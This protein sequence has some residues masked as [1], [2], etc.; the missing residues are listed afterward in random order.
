MAGP[1]EREPVGFSESEKRAAEWEARHDVAARGRVGDPFAVQ[2]Y[3]ARRREA[4]VRRPAPAPA[5]APPAAA[6]AAAAPQPA[7]RPDAASRSR[8][9]V[10][11]DGSPGARTALEVALAEAARRG[12]E[13]DVVTASPLATVWSGGV[14]YTPEQV[15]QIR[16]GAEQ[17]IHA[18]VDEVLADPLAGTPGIDAVDVRV[19]AIE[20]HAARVLIAAAEDADLLVVG[21]R[22]RG[23]VRSTLL[24]SVALHCIGS[25]PCPV[26]V[27]HADARA[28]DQ[29]AGPPRVGAG[30]DGSPG[31]HA[32]LAAAVDEAARVGGEVEVLACYAVTDDWTVPGSVAARSADEIRGQVAESV[33]AAVRDGVAERTDAPAVRIRVELDPAAD[34]LVAHARGAHRLVVGASGHGMVHGLLLG[35]VALH[36]AMHAPAPVLVV[37]PLPQDRS[38]VSSSSN[39][40]TSASTSGTS[41]ESAP[42]PMVTSP[43]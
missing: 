31:A 30:C 25:A 39:A 14:A 32:A 43:A 22:G 9:V 20:G 17:R 26:L 40:V 4:E 27:V 10:G 28:S 23:G 1:S 5:A 37:R 19:L 12:A 34:V 2:H 42:N 33:A 35:S 36:C 8:L 38:S 21:S 7:E 3:L 11:V 6:P 41:V 24:G 16:A 18:V 29:V 13:L 15:R